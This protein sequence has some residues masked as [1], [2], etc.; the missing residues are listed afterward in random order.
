MDS[1]R[2][3]KNDTIGIL[4]QPVIWGIYTGHSSLRAIG[5]QPKLDSL[6]P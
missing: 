2:G 6:N 4:S 3:E 5:L 1:Q